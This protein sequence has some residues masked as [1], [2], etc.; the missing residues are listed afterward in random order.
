MFAPRIGWRTRSGTSSESSRPNS[1]W[2][3]CAMAS[4][5]KTTLRGPTAA[6]VSFHLH[7]DTCLPPDKKTAEGTKP[8][9]GVNA[10]AGL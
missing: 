5:P 8:V 10:P 4:V 1:Q 7:S 6:S 9:A 3:S 2:V